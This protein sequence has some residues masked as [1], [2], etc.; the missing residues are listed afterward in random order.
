MLQQWFVVAAVVG[1]EML[2]SDYKLV[3]PAAQKDAETGELPAGVF[4][5][6]FEGES[7]KAT[8]SFHCLVLT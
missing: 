8:L 1:D 4:T 3:D 2:D 7:M 5:S 6:I